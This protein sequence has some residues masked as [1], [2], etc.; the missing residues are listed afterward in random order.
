MLTEEQYQTLV[1]PFKKAKILF[2]PTQKEFY[3]F[4]NHTPDP[5]LSFIQESIF[6]FDWLI[7]INI[8]RY[9]AE[10]EGIRHCFNRYWRF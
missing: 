9:P 7:D 1:E 5:K 2:L 8:S 3:L 4:I 10:C 6:I